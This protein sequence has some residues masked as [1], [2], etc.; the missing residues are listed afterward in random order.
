MTDD[1]KDIWFLEIELQLS[2]KKHRREIVTKLRDKIM[3]MVNV[4]SLQMFLRN[5]HD[6]EITTEIRFDTDGR[7]Y[8]RGRYD[9]ML[10]QTDPRWFGEEEQE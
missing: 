5:E 3:E 1:K 9:H 7:P 4:R 6:L 10:C 8:L 2:D